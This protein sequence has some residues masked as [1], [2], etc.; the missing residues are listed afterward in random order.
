MNVFSQYGGL[1]HQFLGYTSDVDARTAETPFC[2]LRRR[3]HVIEN[4]DAGAMAYGLF[5]A[6]ETSGPAAND[7]QVVVK[8]SIYKCPINTPD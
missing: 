6:R 5:R 7:G 1:V 8:L 3:S 2:A 4:S